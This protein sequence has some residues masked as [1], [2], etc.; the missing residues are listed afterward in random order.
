M[1]EQRRGK[2]QERRREGRRKRKEGSRKEEGKRFFT[3]TLIV[4]IVF[5]C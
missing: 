5:C 2:K 1:F 3:V 4:N